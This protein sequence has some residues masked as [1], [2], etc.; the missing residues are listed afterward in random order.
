MPNYVNYTSN[1]LQILVMMFKVCLFKI[2]H[3]NLKSQDYSIEFGK[4]F[5]AETRPCVTHDITPQHCG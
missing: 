4:F 3:G 5:K 1:V 2:I